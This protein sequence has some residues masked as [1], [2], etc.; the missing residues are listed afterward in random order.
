M[1][2]EMGVEMHYTAWW[3]TDLVVD[4]VE[5]SEGRLSQAETEPS[6]C[7]EFILPCRL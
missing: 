7:F 4:L 5:A 1:G 2:V 3:T 6:A